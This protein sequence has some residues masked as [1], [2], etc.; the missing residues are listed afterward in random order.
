MILAFGL[1]FAFV[2]TAEGQTP[3]AY[4]DINT[5]EGWAWSRIKQGLPADFA[6]HCGAKL[7]PKAD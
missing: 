1:A 3:T 4:E 7:D 5:P 6:D 2:T